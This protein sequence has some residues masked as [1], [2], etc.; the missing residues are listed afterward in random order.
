LTGTSTTVASTL[1]CFDPSAHATTCSTGSVKKAILKPS[2]PLTAGQFYIALVAP[3]G[4]PAIT[5]FG[6]LT[7]SPTSRSFRA[8]TNE[9]ETSA[10]AS[11]RWRTQSS[12]SAYGSSYTIEHRSGARA[13]FVFSGTSITWYTNIGPN[14]GPAYVYIDG[15]LKGSFNQYAARTHFKVPR[16][17]RGLTS[18][19][20]TFLIVV[21]G[22]KGATSATGTDV[23]LDAFTVGSTTSTTPR[24]VYTW[25]RVAS[26]S[27]S[28]RAYVQADRAGESVSFTFRGTRVDWY[29]VMNSSMGR[30]AV[31]IDGVLK[32]TVDNYAS[33]TRYGVVR[34][35]RGLSNTVHTIKIVVLGTRQSASHGTLI[36]IDRWSVL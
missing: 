19:R 7:V 23:A 11:Y 34:S 5:D 3:G 15:A 26:S 20:H 18:A 32:A 16:S 8:S 25:Q 9:Q 17:F 21:R 30:A 27:A 14:Y 10:G 33:S 28:G 6:G 12:S 36:A 1:A 4:S 29:T 24:T 35:F 31:Y 22:I 13:A 2:A